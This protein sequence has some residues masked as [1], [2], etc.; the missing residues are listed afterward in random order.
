MA[1]ARHQFWI[2][3]ALTLLLQPQ[4]LQIAAPLRR[5]L[6]IE[7]GLSRRHQ[8]G[9]L[10]TALALVQLAG[11]QGQL[12]PP[13]GGPGRWHHRVLVVVEGA[14]DRTQ[15]PGLVQMAAQAF[16]GRTRG[17]HEDGPLLE[18]SMAP[19]WFGQSGEPMGPELII[20]HPWWSR[21]PKAKLLQDSLTGEGL[22]GQADHETK[23]GQATIQEFGTAVET[24]ATVT[25]CAGEIHAWFNDPRI[26]ELGLL[27]IPH[28][29]F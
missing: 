11:Q 2:E 26:E 6:S 25:G 24:P 5:S 20:S 17:G 16:K 3:A 28:P 15:Q 8:I 13:P 4:Q 22:H 1:R 7:L 23:H 19:A 10:I 12:L 18:T 14:A 27:R 21:A 9:Q 29:S